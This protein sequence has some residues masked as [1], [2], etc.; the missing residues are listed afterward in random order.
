MPKNWMETPR[1]TDGVSQQPDSR[2]FRSQAKAVVN[3]WLSLVDGKGKRPGSKHIAEI[4][5][6]GLTPNYWTHWID[7]KAERQDTDPVLSTSV[8]TQAPEQYLIMGVDPQS[9]GTGL[10]RAWD[11]GGTEVHIEDAASASAGGTLGGTPATFDYLSNGVSVAA[12]EYLKGLTIADT[13]ILINKQANCSMDAATLTQ[14]DANGEGFIF[15]RIG[16]Y[17]I[18]Y[19]VRIVENSGTPTT[20]THTIPTYDGTGTVPALGFLG[21]ISTDD[22][23]QNIVEFVNGTGGAPSNMNP[24]EPAYAGITGL[25]ATRVG[26]VVRIVG[27]AGHEIIEIEAT[28]GVGDTSSTVL[29]N[30]VDT[31]VDLPL[32]C[33]DGYKLRVTGDPT[34]GGDDYFI[35]FTADDPTN[36]AFGEGVWEQTLAHDAKYRF[37]PDTMPHRLTRKVHTSGALPS[38]YTPSPGEIYFEFDEIP[39]VDKA[40]GDDTTVPDPSFIGRKIQDVFLY[41]NRLGFLT[42][43]K[44]VMSEVNGFYNFWRTDLTNLL[45]SDT[46]DV[47]NGHTDVTFTTQ[48]MPFESDLIMWS[49][50]DQ[51]RVPGEG[52]LTPKTMG[53]RHITSFETDDRVRPEFSGRGVFFIN[54]NETSSQLLELYRRGD[55]G[56][57]DASE[58]SEQA[59]RYVPGRV[60]E[61]T[62]AKKAGL[63]ALV[64]DDANA[65]N[66]SKVFIYQW[67]WSGR[68]RVQSAWHEWDFGTD[69]KIRSAKFFGD[70]LYLIID[71]DGSTFMEKIDC[72]DGVVSTATD[73]SVQDF[74]VRFDRLF[75]KTSGIT[76]D[77][78]TN[79][80]TMAIPYDLGPNEEVQVMT[81]SNATP[82]NMGVAVASTDRTTPGAHFVTLLGDWSTTKV[83]AGIRYDDTYTFGSILVK[84]PQNGGRSERAIIHGPQQVFSGRVAFDESGP[85]QVEITPRGQSAYIYK[86]TGRSVGDVT[87]GAFTGEQHIDSGELEFPVMADARRVEIVIRNKFGW[88]TK[89]QK[90]EWL[91][92]HHLPFRRTS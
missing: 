64:L 41:K 35:K 48:A 22:I 59:I 45:D 40:V 9:G 21:S 76:Y 46:I 4:L 20:H 54:H 36:S 79:L 17:K 39:W 28:D 69:A 73:G 24:S 47:N 57:F 62:A 7:V 67:H 12:R 3:S 31:F 65:T 10:M 14:S 85:F 15:Y 33:Q 38:G 58:L 27:S 68:E 74:M 49:R 43:D 29:F 66:D 72:A 2:R 84:E 19:N 75:E 88:P 71:R 6:A 34:I 16:N 55:S 32:V 63:L 86:W 81:F 25:S 80:S 30:D 56:L 50:N 87:L 52:V 42:D 8:Q 11:L 70:V 23:A 37:D 44:V 18:N 26:S 51:F 78:M 61:M 5:A 1:L 90:M 13:T 60:R 77:V 92:N 89:L 82:K 83:W 91:V 53:I